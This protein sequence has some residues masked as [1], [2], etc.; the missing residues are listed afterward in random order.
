M[1]IREARQRRLMGGVRAHILAVMAGGAVGVGCSGAAADT[2]S[3]S[4]A[5]RPP[6]SRARFIP[7]IKP[8][9]QAHTTRYQPAQT[10]R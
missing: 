8:V 7:D 5:S 3:M 10:G 2:A 4:L 9:A 6:V 1:A